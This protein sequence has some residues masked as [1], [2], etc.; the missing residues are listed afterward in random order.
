MAGLSSLRRRTACS[1]LWGTVCH[2][3]GREASR[4]IPSILSRR[5][6][7]MP[8][9]G[10]FGAFILLT[11]CALVTGCHAISGSAPWGNEPIES[12]QAAGQPSCD[13]CH[14]EVAARH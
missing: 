7:L 5:A 12:S 9:A 10:P 14:A 13:S 2:H 3:V 1:L 8:D 6:A 4:F 11:V